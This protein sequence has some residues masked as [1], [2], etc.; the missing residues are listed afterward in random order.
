MPNSRR[1]ATRSSEN[2]TGHSPIEIERRFTIIEKT[3][4]AHQEKHDAHREA[5]AGHDQRLTFLEK[6]ILALAGCVYI[7]GQ[8][9]FPEVAS[10]IKRLIP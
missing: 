7:L 9:K 4:E 3:V 6:A 2:Y 10:L 5:H 1:Y 8:E